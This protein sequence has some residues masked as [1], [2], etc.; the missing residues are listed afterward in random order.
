MPITPNAKDLRTQSYYI[1]T[2]TLKGQIN[3][4]RQQLSS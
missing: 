2:I 1:K 3:D 4:P